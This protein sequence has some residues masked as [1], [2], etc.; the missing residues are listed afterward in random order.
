[1]PRKSSSKSKRSGYQ[2]KPSGGTTGRPRVPKK[3]RNQP[4]VSIKVTP[5][6]PSHGVSGYPVT[7]IAGGYNQ[8]Y[9]SA[10]ITTGNLNPAASRY[11]MQTPTTSQQIARGTD[12]SEFTTPHPVRTGVVPTVANFTAEPRTEARLDAFATPSTAGMMA[13]NQQLQAGGGHRRSSLLEETS[14][15]G[16]RDDDLYM[17]T[18]VEG[19]QT[20]RSAETYHGEVVTPATPAVAAN[21]FP[22]PETPA[23]Q[24]LQNSGTRN[25]IASIRLVSPEGRGDLQSI[26]DRHTPQHATAGYAT[27]A[28]HHSHGPQPHAAYDGSWT[29]DVL[30]GERPIGLVDL[31]PAADIP[32]QTYSGYSPSNTS[33]DYMRP[34]GGSY[35]KPSLQRAAVFA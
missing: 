22:V 33:A 5:H 2:Q 3:D 35:I 26:N 17:Q 15:L 32:V 16:G 6:Q 4:I 13:R 24:G 34:A 1:M 27:P 20:N 28:T 19:M 30:P 31:P 7:G 25:P 14:F 11:D 21:L 12:F 10:G 23:R 18:R 9:S 29:L 8:Q